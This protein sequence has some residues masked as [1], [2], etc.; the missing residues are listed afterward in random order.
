MSL[1]E[2]TLYNYLQAGVDTYVDGSILSADIFDG[3]IVTADIADG[4]ILN[5]DVNSSAAIAYSKLSLGSSIVSG[6][7]TDGTIVNADVNAS[8]A[9]VDTKLAQI[10]TASKVSGTSI[11]G[12]ASLPSG[13]GVVPTANLGSGSASSSTFLRGDQTYDTLDVN[14]S[15][16][17]VRLTDYTTT[18]STFDETGGFD[19]NSNFATNKF[20]ATITGKYQTTVCIQ[21]F[22][23]STTLGN[24][25]SATL[26][27]RKN[28]TIIHTARFE[29]P[30]VGA[31][32]RALYI[33]LT[34]STIVDM[35]ATDYLDV[36]ISISNFENVTQSDITKSFWSGAL[37]PNTVN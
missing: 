13:A 15:E 2:N 6:D 21:P 14:K 16:F 36:T 37:I 24:D 5:A 27:L 17:L 18:P 9:I 12:L 19:S 34:I 25:Y 4:T 7:I 31:S 23:S 11:T 22:D 30:S 1:N 10:T 29:H 35:S 28:G 33:P 20:T 26:N 3:T 32:S 8:A